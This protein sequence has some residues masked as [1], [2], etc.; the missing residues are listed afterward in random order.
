MEQSES[1]NQRKKHVKESVSG[2]EELLTI[3]RI[4]ISILVLLIGIFVSLSPGLFY[5]PVPKVVLYTLISLLPAILFGAEAAA[6]FQLDFKAFSFTTVGAAAITFG[7]LFSLTYLSKPEQQI[8]VFHIYDEQGQP[9]IGLDRNDA[10]K[11]LLTNQ[12]YQVTKFVDENAL[13]LIFPEQVDS[14]ELQIKPLSS[15]AIYSGTVK[16]TGNRE[17]KLYLGKHLKTTLSEK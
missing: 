15:G 11:V 8:A 16:Y 5:A 14:C 12:A 17:T 13:V 1:K 9:V 6:K 10:V 7:M 2:S 3:L 4:V